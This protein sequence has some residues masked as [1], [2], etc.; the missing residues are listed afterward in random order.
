MSEE[1]VLSFAELAG[2]YVCECHACGVTSVIELKEEPED[3]LFCPVCGTEQI[4]ELDF[5]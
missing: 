5:N 2:S 4:S 1:R 3:E